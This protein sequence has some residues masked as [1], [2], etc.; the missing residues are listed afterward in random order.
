MIAYVAKHLDQARRSELAMKSNKTIC[1][2]KIHGVLAEAKNTVHARYFCLRYPV[3]DFLAYIYE[4][5]GSPFSHFQQELSGT[6]AIN[7]TIRVFL[8][9]G[10][11]I[12]PCKKVT[13]TFF[14]LWTG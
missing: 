9:V 3:F 4:L 5:T 13:V 7:T 2:N 12:S 1:Q 11:C 14:R 10:F 8:V 6:V